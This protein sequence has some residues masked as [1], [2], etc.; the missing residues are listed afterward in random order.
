MSS[1]AVIA[2]TSRAAKMME[3]GL[4]FFKSVPYAAHGLDKRVE[5]V[6]IKFFADASDKDIDALYPAVKTVRLY[7]VGDVGP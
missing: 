1:R 5:M 2:P 7:T 3:R 4:M 6:R